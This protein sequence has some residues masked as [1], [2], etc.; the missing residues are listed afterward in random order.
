VTGEAEWQKPVTKDRNEVLSWLGV[1][2][3]GASRVR[4]QARSD[5]TFESFVGLGRGAARR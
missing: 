3:K 1:G 2:K 4:D 5:R